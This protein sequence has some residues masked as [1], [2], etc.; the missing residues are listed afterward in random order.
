L[1]A[2]SLWQI[3]VHCVSGIQEL[4]SLGIRFIATSQGLDTDESNSASKLLLH[5]L[6]AVAQFE[7]D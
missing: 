4:T 3:T 5:I 7:R 2:G 1:E 6:G